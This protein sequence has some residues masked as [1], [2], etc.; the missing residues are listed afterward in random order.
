MATYTRAWKEIDE[1]DLW[2]TLSSM[3]TLYAIDMTY[4]QCFWS[5][6]G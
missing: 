5:P 4:S 2:G 6:D 1:D 3:E